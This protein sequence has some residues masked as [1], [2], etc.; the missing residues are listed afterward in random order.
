MACLE[1]AMFVV[2]CRRVFG[3]HSLPGHVKEELAGYDPIQSNLA[4]DRIVATT[5]IML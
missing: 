5:S 1:G 2:C 4:L 3:C